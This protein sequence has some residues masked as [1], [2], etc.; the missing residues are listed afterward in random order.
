[1]NPAFFE[2]TPLA[3]DRLGLAFLCSLEV[4]GRPRSQMRRA[5]LIVDDTCGRAQVDGPAPRRALRKKP[6][7]ETSTVL[8]RNIE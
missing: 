3:V 4:G 1:M 6:S 2:S 5:A 7:M 8:S